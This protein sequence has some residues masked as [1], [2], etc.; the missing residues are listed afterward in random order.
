MKGHFRNRSLTSSLQSLNPFSE[1]PDRKWSSNNTNG[2]DHEKQPRLMQMKD[3]DGNSV[4]VG[5]SRPTENTTWSVGHMEDKNSRWRRSMEDTHIF[6]YD[7]GNAADNGYIAVFDGHAGTQASEYCMKNLHLVLLRKLRQSPTRLV[8]D[9]LDETFVEV[10][11]RIATDTNNEISGC[12]AAVA[13]LRWEDNHSR[14]ML[15]TANVGDARIVLC[16]D[17]KAIRLSYD[18]KGSDR[19]EQKRVSQMGGL[20]V[21]N[22]INGVLAVTRALGDTYLKELVSAHPFTTETHLWKGHDE[23]LIIACDGLWDVISDQEAVDFVR[24]FTSP[25][26]AAARLV[27]YALKRLS[28]DNITCIVVHLDRTTDTDDFDEAHLSSDESY[29]NDYY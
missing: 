29:Q 23:F 17:A 3:G 19:N 8:T 15:Y 10:N 7:F 28:T 26:E 18:H 22:R 21:Q 11:K 6:L 14:Q 4:L 25:R 9:L 5:S 1:G 20:V 24:R 13:L 16:R 27:Q 12:T 2:G